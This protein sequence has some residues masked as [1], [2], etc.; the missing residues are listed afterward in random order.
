MNEIGQSDMEM[1]DQ[2]IAYSPIGR[3]EPRKPLG[4]QIIVTAFQREHRQIK[5]HNKTW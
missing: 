3:S 2:Y 4:T 1:R 5:V